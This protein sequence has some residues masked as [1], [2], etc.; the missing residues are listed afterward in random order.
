MLWS[1]HYAI[2]AGGPA[3]A[4]QD[5]ILPNASAG[6]PCAV[7]AYFLLT[8]TAI[9]FGANTT[10][11]KLAVGEVSPMVVVALR[12]LLVVLLLVPF[13]A[14]T[15]AQDW[16]ILKPRL[17]YLLLMGAVGLSAFTGVF[18]IATHHTTAIN[19]GII[20]GTL[21]VFV[22]VGAL[23]VYR[24][25]IRNVQLVGA[26]VTIVGVAVVASTGDFDRLL[27]VRLNKGDML[28]FLAAVLYA[29]YT[30]G[31][32][33]QPAATAIGLFTVLA[34]AAF[35]TTLPMVAA[36]AW[37]GLFQAP[38]L[39]GWAVIVVSAVFPTLLAQMT[40]LRGVEI[41]G[42]GRAGVFINLVP[43]FGAVFAVLYLGEAFRTFH[44]IALVLVLGGIWIAERAVKAAPAQ[45]ISKA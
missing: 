13:N 6:T 33:K 34:S 17:G 19:M 37:L 10:L 24:T 8:F 39:R 38:T 14:R 4:C 44:G 42:P 27:Q 20:G 12:W 11:A 16:P 40:F 21:P 9:C 29:G 36:Q 23:L 32:R 5:R 35:L 15:W 22:L 7:H 45:S 26:C 28:I 41:I 30:L 18:F 25:P 2:R 1:V 3:R 43:V 31:L